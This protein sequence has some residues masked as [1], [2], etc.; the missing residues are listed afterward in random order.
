MINIFLGQSLLLNA[1]ITEACGIDGLHFI[2]AF[3]FPLIRPYLGS[4]FPDI[5]NL[6]MNDAGLIGMGGSPISDL[7]LAPISVLTSSMLLMLTLLIARHSS[8]NKLMSLF[9]VLVLVSIF[10]Y[11]L[12]NGYI[13]SVNHLVTLFIWILI[14]IFLLVKLHLDQKFGRG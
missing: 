14:P 3:T 11:F 2:R 4:F 13:A 7:I 10:P 9:L 1:N 5:A 12:R 8:F 6:C